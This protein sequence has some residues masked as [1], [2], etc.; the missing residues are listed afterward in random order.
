MTGVPSDLPGRRAVLGA[1]VA[2]CVV[3]PR[4]LGAAQVRPREV[5]PWRDLVLRPDLGGEP[6]SILSR[7]RHAGAISSLVYRGVEYA[8]AADHGRLMQGAIAFNGR[9]ECDNPTQAGG[10]RDRLNIGGRSSSRRR[11]AVIH[12]DGFETVTTM[13]YWKRPGTDCE[14]PGLGSSPADNRTR[15]SDVDYGW[16]HRFGWSGDPRAVHCAVRYD[17]A[18]PRRSAVVEALT[19][20]TP[21]MFDTMLVLDPRTRSLTEEAALLPDEIREP[22]IL[23][24]RDRAHAI[25]FAS[26]TP[27]AWYSRYRLATN[28]KISLVYRPAG[29]VAGPLCAEAV[30][31]V[32]TVAE[33]AATLLGADRRGS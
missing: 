32:G 27:D 9:Y 24:T 26:L 16:R 13:A 31:T 11:R 18:A 17:F 8:D 14:I 1:A 28:S 21:T 12:P 3:W 25:G 6:V 23:A 10:S 29:P 22:V 33:V 4:A 19:I 2:A 15:L 30:W 20:H 7:A 5:A